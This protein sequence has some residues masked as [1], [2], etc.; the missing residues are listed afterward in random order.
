MNTTSGSITSLRERLSS[1]TGVWEGT[2]THLTPGGTLLETYGSRQETRLEG[3]RWYERVVYLREG[4]EP[5]VLDFRARFESEDD[6]VFGSTDFEGRA[7]LV[8]GRFLLFPYR[9][10]AEPGVEVVEL[11]TF[12]DEDYRSRLWKRFRDR[13]LEQITVVEEHRVHGGIPEVW[14]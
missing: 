7:R 3:D 14:H 9:W 11:I 13:R 10:S 5:E 8:D 1:V 6:L 12:A 2:Y 4:A